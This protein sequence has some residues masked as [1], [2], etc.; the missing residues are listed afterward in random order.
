MMN[1]AE[2]E[3]L[4]SGLSIPKKKRPVGTLA[5]NLKERGERL[6]SL[7]LV[8][9]VLTSKRVNKEAFIN[10]MTSIW[11]VSEGV[12]IE[13]IEG[14]VF[15]FHFKNSEDRKYIQSGGPWTFDR[16]ITA[17]EEPSSTGDIAHMKFNS[18][19]FWVQ[20]HNIPL[21][22]MTEDTGT[23]L[24]SMIGEGRLQQCF[25]D[26]KGCKITALSAVD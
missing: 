7:C 26:M 16:A 3:M 11:T 22:C 19:E 15:A 14:N 20:I 5:T 21:L 12:E 24:G 10:V 6:L 25:S 1:F 4:C 18:V 8:G 17:F 9:K 2:L 23:F 13:A